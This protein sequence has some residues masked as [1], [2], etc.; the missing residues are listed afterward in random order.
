MNE[1]TK[2]QAE[3]QPEEWRTIAGYE[4]YYEV[5]SHGR[6]RSLPRNGT[7]RRIRIIKT[8]INTH[9]RPQVGLR[10]SGV[11]RFFTVHALVAGAFLGPRPAGLVVNH[12]DFDRTN[13]H[14]SN[15]EYITQR[16]NIDHALEGGRFYRG[17]ANPAAKLTEAQ[18]RQIRASTESQR[19]CARRFGVSKITVQRIRHGIIW[20]HVV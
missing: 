3:K 1:Q 11:R 18:V 12:K 15:L 8:R 4:G 5:S 14:V 20:R 16:Q 6:V 13:N 17:E 7:V 9:G 10:R 19:A 2:Q